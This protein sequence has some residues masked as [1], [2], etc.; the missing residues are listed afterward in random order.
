MLEKL[1]ALSSKVK[2]RGAASRTLKQSFVTAERR[3]ELAPEVQEVFDY[4]SQNQ[5]VSVTNGRIARGSGVSVQKVGLAVSELVARGLVEKVEV[6][7]QSSSYQIIGGGDS[8]KVSQTT[9]PN[10]SEQDEIDFVKTSEE[11]IYRFV[12]ATRTTDVFTYLTW[13]ER[14]GR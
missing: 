11:L 8:S 7:R 9:A 3:P 12:R 1:K 5:N 4:L 10:G 13:L 14:G 2:A 6:T